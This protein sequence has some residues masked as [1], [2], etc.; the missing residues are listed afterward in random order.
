MTLDRAFQITSRLL[1]LI[2]LLS[3]ILTNEFSILFGLTAVSA[4][5]VSFIFV[6]IEKPFFFDRRVWTVLNLAAMVFFIADLFLVSQSLLTAS[7]H[8]VVF[9][10]INKLFNLRTPQDHSQLYLI[11]FL[12]LLAASTYTIDVT[13][14]VSFVLYLLT[15]TWALLLHHLTSETAT[16]NARAAGRPEATPGL[17][18]PFFFSTNGIALLSLGCT[19]LLFLLIPR[20]GL[21]FF[22]RSQSSLIRMS[23][24][25]E[26]VDLGAIGSVKRD[27]TVVMRI[28]PSRPLPALEGIYWR[29]MVFDT[30]DGRSWRNSFGIGRELSSEGTGVFNLGYR[31]YPERTITQE[32]I[33]E[34]LDTAVLFGVPDPI[35]VSGRF[36]ALRV[37]EMNAVSLPFVPATRIDY[38]F[39][40]MLPALSS[41]DVDARTFSY[42]R[43]SARPYLQM[44]EGSGRIGRLAHEILDQAPSAVTVLQQITAIEKYL[45]SNYRYTLDVPP[46]S[47]GMPIEDFLFRQKAGFCEHYATAMTLLLRSLG[48]PARFVTGFLPGE[49]NEFGKYYTV[50]Q[51]NAHAWVEVWFPQSGWIPF[52]PTPSVPMETAGP[53]MGFLSRSMDSIRWGWNRHVIYYSLQDQISMAKEVKDDSMRLRLEILNR[54]GGAAAAVRRFLVASIRHPVM[55]ILVLLLGGAASVW[56]ARRFSRAGGWRF[57]RWPGRARQVRTVPF[58]FEMLDLLRVKGLSK[59]DTLTPREFLGKIPASPA[60]LRPVADELTGLYYR[61]RFAD[62]PLTDLEKHRVTELLQNLKTAP[63][64]TA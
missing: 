35:Q 16:P 46:T 10:T 25:S 43:S 12:Q 18:W 48:I 31:K 38:I 51:S 3:L 19:L 22:H 45:E 54:V 63:P 24:F 53:I 33:L 21:G 17:S 1:A 58:Y 40:S 62:I 34:P 8:F 60:P 30:Y 39:T 41:P 28:Q 13:F 9:L 2:G 56:V 64:S 7:T 5:T 59:P 47:S 4:V 42:S 49:W 36:N 20:V 52:D 61:V 11:S 27:P 57:I 15:A 26:E 44:P 50:R 23:G 6:L 55:V 37:N 29:G 14:L 32:V